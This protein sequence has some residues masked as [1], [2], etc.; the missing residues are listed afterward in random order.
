MFVI[1]ADQ[2]SS[3]RRRDAVEPALVALGKLPGTGFVRPFART[4]GDE[5]QATLDDPAA[6]VAALTVLNRLDEWSIGVGVGPVDTLGETS[7]S[8][9]GPAYIAA[10]EAVEKARSKSVPMPLVVVAAG[11][12]PDRAEIAAH[13]QGLAQLI[14][15]VQ[16]RRSAAG[17]EVIDHL[18]GDDPA[19][20]Q[21]E[22]ARRLDISPAAVS[23]RLRAAMWYETGAA[24]PLLVSLF[25]RL[26]EGK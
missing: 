13:A 7:A 17:W 14:G 5:I 4:V 9:A 10:R 26:E 23:N 1:T 24:M 22:V 21:A 3:R 8:S 25:N 16:R 11:G 6:V 19:P 12:G 20:T 2:E 15:Q 18:S